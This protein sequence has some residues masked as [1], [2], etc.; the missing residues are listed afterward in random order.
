[1]GKDKL[2]KWAENKTFDH[3]FEPPIKPHAGGERFEM[4]GN[5]N[6]RV[7][8]N[9]RPITLEL[10]CGKGEYTVGLGRL[11]PERNFIGVDIKGHRF[12]RGAKTSNEESMNNVAFL[13]ARI[14][15]IH[16]YFSP[17]EVDQIWLTFSDPQPKHEKHRI[18]GPLF[19]EKY[20]QFLKPGGWVHIKTDNTDLYNWSMEALQDAGYEIDVHTDNVY[21]SFF[22]ELDTD[23]QQ[24]LAIRTY[25][26]QKFAEQGSTIKYLRFQV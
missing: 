9:D 18:T 5:W 19:M 6:E 25:Y 16:H 23:W 12:W 3:V 2:K 4:S 8:G 11:Y 26:E 24:V 17:N 21:A 1:M 15:F 13:R 7:F 14:E 10:G 22:D 20:K